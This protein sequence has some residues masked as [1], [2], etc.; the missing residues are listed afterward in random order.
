MIRLGRSRPAVADSRPAAGEGGFILVSVLIL[1]VILLAV[2]LGLL[3]ESGQA[4]RR[5]SAI[6]S[7]VGR[8]A[9]EG[10]LKVA[11]LA[12]YQARLRDPRPITF[13][14]TVSGG[15]G[16]AL[17]RFERPQARRLDWRS[18]DPLVLSKFLQRHR[19]PAGRADRFVADLAGIGTLEAAL[20]LTSG[21]AV[22]PLLAEDHIRFG[23][24]FAGPDDLP[25]GTN[26]LDLG[27]ATPDA[28]RLVFTPRG[29]DSLLAARAKART[30][31][32]LVPGD[33][34][35][36]DR[37]AVAALFSNDAATQWRVSLD[38]SFPLDLTLDF[39]A[40]PFAPRLSQP[41][42]PR[43]AGGGR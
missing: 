36:D 35:E 19:V 9:A 2:T 1:M 33:L 8:V 13:E 38:G 24:V 27:T 42:E 29:A 6:P 23:A 39:A 18:L 7:D 34:A 32:E 41:A 3:T 12:L 20:R 28:L 5:F 14:E 22:L 37:A 43:A 40:K 26:R 30:L 15:W 16:A 31:A 25:P 21:I 10:R 4:N 17:L 11:L